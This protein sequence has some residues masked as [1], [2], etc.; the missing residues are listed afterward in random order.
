MPVS[1]RANNG[2][3]MFEYIFATGSKSSITPSRSQGSALALR[4]ISNIPL[5]KTLSRTSCAPSQEENQASMNTFIIFLLIIK[6]Q[7]VRL[8]KMSTPANQNY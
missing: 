7:V 6:N 2:R 4:N 5:E 8:F 3:E 1:F